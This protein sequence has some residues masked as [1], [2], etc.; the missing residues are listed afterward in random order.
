MAN[1]QPLSDNLQRA[2]RLAQIRPK[3]GLGQNFLVDS[4]SLD[5]IVAAA[6]I[7]PSDVILEVGPGLG[8]LTSKLCA[9]A[10]KVVAVEADEHL[11]DLLG[12]DAPTNLEIKA[13]DIMAFDLTS[14][15]P[16][17]K[18]VA[19]IPYYLTSK[20]LRYLIESPR[21]PSSMTLLIQKEVAERITA[22]PGQLS[23][24]ALSIQY[25]AYAKIVAM[26]ERH[27]FWPSP[28]VDSAVLAIKRRPKPA[29][30]A[31]PDQ[32]FRLIK[33]GFGER[34]KQLKNSLAGGLNAAPDV[35][36]HTLAAAKLDPTSRAQELSLEDWQHLY[37]QAIQKNLV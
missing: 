23:T 7:K 26:V 2:V 20:L 1:N 36:E 19:N 35:I 28:K 4:A 29:F 11:A 18:V 33:A 22:G 6:E 13:G 8:F 14:L 16:E 31:D 21:P 17:Y 15:P 27:K 34:R 5:V 10:A 3:K 24:L 9:Q 30:A 12:E 25:Y 32:L 37:D